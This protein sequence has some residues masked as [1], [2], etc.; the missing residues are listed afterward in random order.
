M[1]A[2]Y[3]ICWEESERGWGTRPDGYTFHRSELLA[4]QY[5]V[6]FNSKMSKHIPDVY[7]RPV[8]DPRLIEVSQGLHDYVMKYG[9]VWLV[10]TYAAAYKNY[11]AA[12]LFA[13]KEKT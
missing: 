13:S 4:L 1:N 12:H 6:V 8:G 7:S 9:D 2:L 10:P 5:V 11:D 3:A